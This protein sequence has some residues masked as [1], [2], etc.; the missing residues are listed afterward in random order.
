MSAVTTVSSLA[1]T[2]GPSTVSSETVVDISNQTVMPSTYVA[3]DVTKTSSITSSQ[4][5]TSPEASADSSDEIVEYG[6][7]KEP[8]MLE[9]SPSFY[10]SSTEAATAAVSTPSDTEFPADLTSTIFSDESLIISATIS[11]LFTTEKPAVTTASD[12][13]IDDVCCHNC[14]FPGKHRGTI[15]SVIRN[16]SGYFKSDSDAINICC[17]R[18]HKDQFHNQLSKF[19]IT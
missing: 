17:L 5:S 8:I 2:E 10:G 9:S 16:C 12:K 14:I 19:N 13:A 7:S 1:S 4:S 18:C 3:S 15:H 6:V 11:S